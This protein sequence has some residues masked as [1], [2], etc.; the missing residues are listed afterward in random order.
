[1]CIGIV[2]DRSDVQVGLHDVFLVRVHNQ[3]R[4]LIDRDAEAVDAGL[5][6]A[7]KHS[8]W[9]EAVTPRRR[10]RCRCMRADGMGGVLASSGEPACSP[11][12]GAEGPSVF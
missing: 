5:R 2:D 3:A 10:L 8:W 1:M 12:T 4:L 11:S 9:S 6:V 7:E